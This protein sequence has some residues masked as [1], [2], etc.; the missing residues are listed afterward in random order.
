MLYYSI[1]AIA[2]NKLFGQFF[3]VC[4]RSLINNDLNNQLLML[5][6]LI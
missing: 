5:I 4:Q 2:T 1:S 3:F 6:Y